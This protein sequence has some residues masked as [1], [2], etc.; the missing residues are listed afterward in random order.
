M[1]DGDKPSK[2]KQIVDMYEKAGNYTIPKEKIYF[3]DDKKMNVQYFEKA[4]YNARQVSCETR[5]SRLNNDIGLCGA[6]SSEIVPLNG[7][8][9]CR[10]PSD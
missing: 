7:V 6:T 1:A 9:Y 2:V 3:F 8:S 10:N 5:D 4:G